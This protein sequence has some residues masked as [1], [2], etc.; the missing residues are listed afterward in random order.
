MRSGLL[1]LCVMPRTD[2]MQ[3]C[4]GIGSALTCLS[5]QLSALDTAVQF[6]HVIYKPKPPFQPTCLAFPQRP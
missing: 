4:E 1:S 3:I 5:W 2:A 6:T